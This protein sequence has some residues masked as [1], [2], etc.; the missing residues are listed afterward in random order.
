MEDSLFLVAVDWACH[1]HLKTEYPP[2]GNRVQN[3]GGTGAG[4]GGN[5]NELGRPLLKHC[6]LPKH[7]C[8]AASGDSQDDR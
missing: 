7:K 5:N 2:N 3:D 6:G 1:L 8:R 4:F